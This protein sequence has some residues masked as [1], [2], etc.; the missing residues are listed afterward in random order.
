MDTSGHNTKPH[1]MGGTSDHVHLDHNSSPYDVFNLMMSEEFRSSILQEC[2]NM[3]AEIEGS[4]RKGYWDRIK[5]PDFTLSSREEIYSYL[6]LL[7]DHGISM[8]PQIKLWF[9]RNHDSTICGNDNVSKFFSRGRR[10]WDEFKRFFCMYDPHTYTKSDAAKY[11]LFKVRRML[12][13]LQKNFELYWDS[14]RGLSIHEKLLI[15]RVD[16]KG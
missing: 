16:T 14:E 5:Y 8:K 2:M 13:H 7:L 15:F 11:S 3:R 4:G 1:H 10:R 9:L 6:V 12:Q